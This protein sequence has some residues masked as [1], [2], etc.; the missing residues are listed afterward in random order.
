MYHLSGPHNM[1]LDYIPDS[2]ESLVCII[3]DSFDSH[4]TRRKR[5]SGSL[6]GTDKTSTFVNGRNERMEQYADF[7]MSDMK[8][9]EE[10]NDAKYDNQDGSI[11]NHRVKRSH[12]YDYSSYVDI[13]SCDELTA[14]ITGLLTV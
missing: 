2:L 13:D 7:D 8:N 4:R 3:P 11:G 5:Q 1:G 14:N 12:T 9:A 6:H 10:M